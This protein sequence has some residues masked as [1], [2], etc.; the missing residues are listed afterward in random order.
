MDGSR[1]I[2]K[3]QPGAGGLSTEEAELRLQQYG[4]DRLPEGKRRSLLARAVAQ[5]NNLLI[6]V[7]LGATEP[8]DAG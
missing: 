2:D 7:L 1:A 4:L 6:Y 5:I 3:L 8:G